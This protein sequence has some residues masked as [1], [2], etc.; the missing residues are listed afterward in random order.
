MAKVPM[1]D[2]GIATAGMS[3]ERTL[4][5]KT[6][7]STTTSAKAMPSVSQTSLMEASTKMDSS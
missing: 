3:V 4:P 2:T 1:M 5:R 6:Q 7:M